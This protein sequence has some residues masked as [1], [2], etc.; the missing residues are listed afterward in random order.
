MTT[1]AEKPRARG[2]GA[3]FARIDDG[4]IVRTAFYLMLLGTA[5][6]LWID[7]RELMGTNVPAFDPRTQP[8]LP[9][10]DPASP[11]TPVGPTV[12]TAPELL[13]Q[14][15][16]AELTS[17][18]TLA[19]T[20]AIDPGSA[21]RVVAEV[22]THG[23]YI[24]TVALDSPGGSVTDA[25]AIGRLIR[26]KGYTTSVAPGSI[27]ASSCPLIFA[28]GTQRLATAESAIGVHQIYAT[29]PAASLTE[30]LQA[31]GNAL[32]NAQ[33]TTAEISRY[34]NEM[35]IDPEVWLH[36]LE[37]PPDKLY[38]FSADELISLKLVTK[39]TK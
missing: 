21:E 37:T 30:R 12:T 8:I 3:L 32:S 13:K 16:T 31:A 15:L 35:G 22:A 34:I 25:L 23:E 39:L 5:A 33:K 9:A 28:G 36:A 29:T 24:K 19:L 4:A 38:Y 11:D 18:G 14:P 7:Y 10:F 27:C 26:E 6:V 17:G 2:L 20:G 1:L